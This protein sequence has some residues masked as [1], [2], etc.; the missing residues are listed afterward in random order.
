VPPEC[1]AADVEPAALPDDAAASRGPL[2][3]PLLLHPSNNPIRK[4]GPRVAP[5]DIIVS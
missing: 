3:P 2:P 4:R 5:V 1:D